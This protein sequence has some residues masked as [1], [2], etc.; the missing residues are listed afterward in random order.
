MLTYI[1]LLFFLLGFLVILG[2]SLNSIVVN[3][4]TTVPM[5]TYTTTQPTPTQTVQT[6]IPMTTTQFYTQ[7]TE[8]INDDDIPPQPYPHYIKHQYSLATI[9]VSFLIVTVLCCL[10]CSVNIKYTKQKNYNNKTEYTPINNPN[11]P[12]TY[13]PNNFNKQPPPYYN[14]PDQNQTNYNKN[15]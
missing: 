3:L 2:E 10:C 5:S 14:P 11:Y 12:Q 8:I 9:C 13:I 4:N 6:T 1:N 7:T 15:V